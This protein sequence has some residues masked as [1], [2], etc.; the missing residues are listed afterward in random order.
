MAS[1]SAKVEQSLA[2]QK[3]GLPAAGD[4][5]GVDQRT[6]RRYIT[7]GKLPAWSLA[8]GRILRVRRGDVEALLH[9]LPANVSDAS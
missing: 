5:I 9:P 8:G 3:I 1:R 4:L 2:D 7:D 6:I